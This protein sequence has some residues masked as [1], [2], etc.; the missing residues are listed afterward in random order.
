MRTAT[1]YAIILLITFS[2]AAFAQE[3]GTFTDPRDKKKYNTVKIG[4]FTWMAQ[5]LNYA[6]KGSKCPG[7]EKIRI[8]PCKDKNNN[9]IDCV[10]IECTDW[11][12]GIDGAFCK[13]YKKLTAKQIQERDKKFQ[14][15]CAIS[16]RLYEWEAASKA[17]PAGWH[18]PNGKA[19]NILLEM[20]GGREE[21]TKGLKLT[22]TSTGGTDDFG[23]NAIPGSSDWWSSTKDGGG[24]YYY[25]IDGSRIDSY[26][27]TDGFKFIRC[28]Q[29]KSSEEVIA[30]IGA[31][32]AAEK[33]PEMKAKADKVV[34]GTFTDDRDK[35][36][37]KT[38]KIGEQ[39]WMAENLSYNADDSKCYDN[40]P[41]N[42]DKYGRLY[43]DKT[44]NKVCPNGWKIPM[45]KEWKTLVDFAGGEEV[46]GNALK[47]SSGWNSNGKDFFGFSALP[48]GEAEGDKFTNVGNTG[49]WWT[50]AYPS[51]KLTIENVTAKTVKTSSAALSSVRCIQ[52]GAAT[53]P[54]AQQ[55]ASQP[56]AQPQ[57]Q[58]A[59]ENCAITFPKKTCVSMP[60]GSCKMAGGKVVDKCP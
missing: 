59:N 55:P 41:A 38:V 23:F 56:A 44:I 36:T 16:G 12:D 18:L 37:Y 40:K 4:G 57:Q 32:A 1:K 54:A 22:A 39:T 48:G 7:E 52:G 25:K 13:A 5:N 45:E 2:I 51:A 50:Y 19:W 30:A 6:A 31:A 33:E 17:C 26:R 47:A 28:A 42:C 27:T 29:G 14:A 10:D 60:A 9:D 43:I 3:K 24:F 53:Q 58:S 15:D 34:K 21:K 46:A 8:T 11:G 49:S 35:K 20:A